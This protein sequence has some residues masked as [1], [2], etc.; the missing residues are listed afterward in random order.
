MKI[1]GR[2]EL[3]F[4]SLKQQLKVKSFVGALPN[5]LLSQ[6]WIAKY[7]LL[8]Y[9]NSDIIFTNDL[10][11]AVNRVRSRFHNFLL[12]GRRV[13]LD[14]EMSLDFSKPDWKSDLREYTYSRGKLE[15]PWGGID[16]FVYPKGIWNAIPPFAIGRLRWDSWLLYK[17]RSNG[18][19]LIDA[20]NVVMAIH[21][22]HDY[23]HHTH[24]EIGV[25][26]R[27]EAKHNFKLLGGFEYIF[28]I[29]NAT[30][31]L[32]KSDFKRNLTFNPVYI[33]R[34]LI[35]LPALYPSLRPLIKLFK[36]FIKLWLLLKV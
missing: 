5:V 36:P 11:V 31:Q 13:N 21:Q 3:F 8:C 20:T 28:T 25:W 32:T 6:L 18:I 16:Y 34:R 15:P 22:N 17:A 35:I 27:H 23:S 1:V 2:F 30:H 9:V 10:L 29:L 14:L 12:S 4:K 26:K 33:A 19:P 24:G 7:N